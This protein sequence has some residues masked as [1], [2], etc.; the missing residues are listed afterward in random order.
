M[1]KPMNWN[2]ARR[3]SPRI[4]PM[5][6]NEPWIFSDR[7]ASL[8]KIT[9]NWCDV[10]NN[11]HRRRPITVVSV[12][13]GRFKNFVRVFDVVRRNLYRNFAEHQRILYRRCIRCNFPRRISR[14]NVPR[15]CQSCIPHHL[16]IPFSNSK[17]IGLP[18][19]RI[20]SIHRRTTS[21]RRWLSYVID[22]PVPKISTSA[23]WNWNGILVNL[24]SS[25]SAHLFFIFN[26]PDNLCP[27][28][29]PQ[30]SA[31]FHLGAASR[32]ESNIR[33]GSRCLF[34]YFEKKA[35]KLSA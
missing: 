7:F 29:D 34:V 20:P 5:S 19:W 4:L 17:R 26:I 35:R 23:R 33:Q 10:H 11:R 25:S 28:T 6:F 24:P 1:S 27:L 21:N 15:P 32:C 18:P 14:W 22:W 30:I 13:V 12:A 16:H 3:N 2:H 31:L 8:M 9:T